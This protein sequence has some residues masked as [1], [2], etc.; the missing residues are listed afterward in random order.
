MGVRTRYGVES[1]GYM[2]YIELGREWR[3]NGYMC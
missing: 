1:S 2:C 3:V